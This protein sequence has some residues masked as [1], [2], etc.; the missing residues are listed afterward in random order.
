M[1]KW[2]DGGV[3]EKKEEVRVVFRFLF[4]FGFGKVSLMFKFLERGILLWI[5]ELDIVVDKIFLYVFRLSSLDGRI[6]CLKIFK[7]LILI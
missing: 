7:K 5:F 2:G 3:F 6:E 4:N 1:S